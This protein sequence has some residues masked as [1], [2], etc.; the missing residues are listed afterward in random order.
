MQPAVLV[1][2]YLSL[3]KITRPI[4]RVVCMHHLFPDMIQTW[5]ANLGHVKLQ[6]NMFGGKSCQDTSMD[7]LATSTSAPG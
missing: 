1:E 5:N 3:S 4:I 7:C 2:I 6:V